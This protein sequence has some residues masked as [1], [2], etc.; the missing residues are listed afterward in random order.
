MEENVDSEQPM[1]LV[2]LKQLFQNN[3]KKLK[4]KILIDI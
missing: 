3:L 4:T 2:L 1:I